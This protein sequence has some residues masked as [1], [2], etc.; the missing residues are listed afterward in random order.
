M[1]E[2]PAY[3]L[4]LNKIVPADLTEDFD[5]GNMLS[6]TGYSSDL[7]AQVVSNIGGD[8]GAGDYVVML[9]RNAK[10]L[11]SVSVASRQYD[12]SMLSMLEVLRGIGY[13]SPYRELLSATDI[14]CPTQ[15]VAL[16]VGRTYNSDLL[17]RNQTGSFGYGWSFEWDRKLTADDKGNLSVTLDSK[18]AM[19]YLQSD[20][21]FFSSDD[22]VTL[23]KNSSGY[24]MTSKDGTQLQYATDGSLRSRKDANGNTVTATYSSG[25][26]TKLAHSN[27]QYLTFAR[28]SSGY[29]SSVTD[30]QG[31]KV[32]YTY[33]SKGNLT[34]VSDQAAGTMER[35]TYASTSIHSLTSWTAADGTTTNFTYGADGLLSQI[36][37]RGGE[38]AVTIEYGPE[39]K[40]TVEDKQGGSLTYC[41][42]ECGRVVKTVDNSTGVATTYEHGNDGTIVSDSRG[43]S[44]EIGK[45]SSGR[46]TSLTD[47]DGNSLSLT[48][49]SKGNIA[50]MTDMYGNTAN[51]TYD[52]KNNVTRVSHSDG[53]S[54]SMT[55][56]SNG[57]L[58]TYK[59]TK[60]ITTSFTYNTKG[61]VLSSARNGNTTSY[62]YDSNGNLAG[63]T[64]A[65]SSASSFQYDSQSHLSVFTDAKGNSINYTYDAKGNMTAIGRADGTSETFTYNAYNDLTT[66]KNR[67][68]GTVKY[69]Y[70]A[71]G[72]VTKIVKSDGTTIQY[73]YDSQS[74]LTQAGGMT[75]TYDAYDNLKTQTL[76]GKTLTYQYDSQDRIVSISDGNSTTKYSYTVQG[77]L[78]KLTNA[79]GALLVD[80]DYD[81]QGRLSKVTNGNGTYSRYTYNQYGELSAI[82]NY[83]ASGSLT[84]YNRYTYDSNG[85]C[86]TKTTKDGTWTYTY[87]KIGQLTAAVL[88]NSS[89]S[90][91]RNESY[92]YDTVGN[93]VKSVIDGVTTTYVYDA[94]NRIVSATVGGKK[95]TYRYD[96]DGNLLEDEKRIYTWTTDNRV[97]TEKDKA[98]GQIWTYGYDALGNRISSTTNGVTTTWAV[99]ANGN[100]LAE[101]VNGVWQRSYIQ[102]SGLAGWTDKNGNTY[103]FSSD[104]LCSTIAVTDKNG[105]TVNTYSY[106]SFGN[107]ISANETVDNAFQFVG[108]YGLM[109]NESGTI[110][111]RA[112]NYDPVTGRWISEDPIGIN[113]GENLYVYCENNPISLIDLYGYS[114]LSI[115]GRTIENGSILDSKSGQRLT[116]YGAETFYPADGGEGP[117]EKIKNNYSP[118]EGDEFLK[119]NTNTG[120]GSNSQQNGRNP[121]KKPSSTIYTKQGEKITVEL[122]ENQISKKSTKQA[123]QQLLRITAKAIEKKGIAWTAKFLLK[124]GVKLTAK[125]GNALFSLAFLASDFADAKEIAD[126][127]EQILEEENDD[128]SVSNINVDEPKS[129]TVKAT[130][131][132]SLTQP[133]DIYRTFFISQVG[134]TATAGQDF[135]NFSGQQVVIAPRQTSATFSVT[136]NSDSEEE[137]EEYFEVRVSTAENDYISKVRCTIWDNSKHD[138]VVAVID[139]SGSMS[140]SRI[141][142][143]KQA[144]VRVVNSM[145]D[146]DY[147]GVVSFAD[148]ASTVY[149]LNEMSDQT[150]PAAISAINGVSAGGGTYIGAGLDA[151]AYQLSMLI[152]DAETK[153]I[154]LMSDGEDGNPSGTR[155]VANRIRSYGYDIYGIGYGNAY[156]RSIS[157]LQ[158]IVE[159][160]GGKYYFAENDKDLEQMFFD[161]AAAT[162]GRKFVFNSEDSV[163]V[164][165]ADVFTV[166]VDSTTTML[167]LGANWKTVNALE[168]VAIDPDGNYFTTS[169]NSP[170]MKYSSTSDT[171]YYEISAPTIGTWAFG[172]IGADGLTGT[173]NYTAY[174]L[175]T[176]PLSADMSFSATVNGV[177]QKVGVSL[178]VKNGDTAVIGATA[179]A[180]ILR[181][182]GTTETLDLYDDG[183]HGDG[184][185][186]DGVYANFTKQTAGGVYKVAGVVEGKLSSGDTFRRQTVQE[187]FK[188]DPSLKFGI[189]E[190]YSSGSLVDSDTDMS[191]VILKSGGNNSMFVSEGGVATSTI[192]SSGGSVVVRNGGRTEKTVLQ[193]GGLEMISSGGTADGTIIQGIRYSGTTQYIAKGGL[194]INT[195]IVG[196]TSSMYGGGQQLIVGGNAIGTVIA[197]GGIQSLSSGAIASNTVISKYGYQTVWYCSAFDTTIEGG[198]QHVRGSAV[199]TV[200]NSGVQDV[201][202][203]A[204]STIINSGGTQDVNCYG[205]FLPGTNESG[206]SGGTVSHTVINSGGKQVVN[207]TA[208][209][210]ETTVNAGGVQSVYGKMYRS[211]PDDYLSNGHGIISQ[212]MVNSGG[213]VIV[214]SEGVAK[215]MVVSVGGNL[216]LYSGAILQDR[217][218]WGGNISVMSSG[219]IVADEAEIVFDITQ[220]KI[221]DT[222]I[223][224]NIAKL[225]G[226]TYFVSVSA[227]QAEGQYKLANNA[228]AFNQSVTLT[229]T[230]TQLTAQLTKGVTKTVNGVGYTLNVSNGTLNLN[231]V[232]NVSSG[233]TYNSRII[234]AGSLVLSNG[235]TAVST[236]VLQSGQVIV[237]SGGTAKLTRVSSGG[238]VH[239]SSGGT[240]LSTTLISGGMRVSSGGT[241]TGIN[242]SSGVFLGLTIARDTYIQGTSGGKSFTMTSV[243]SSIEITSGYVDVLR[244]GTLVSAT[245]NSGGNLYAGVGGTISS[246][247]VKSGGYLSVSSGGMVSSA[248]V[249]SGGSLYVIGGGI[250]HGSIELGGMM[251]FGGA[252]VASGANI[253]FDVSQRKI[254]DTVIVNDVTMVA[255][256]TYSVSVAGNQTNGQYKLA[257]N[258]SSFSQSVILTVKD[259]NLATTLTKGVK[260]TVGGKDYTLSVVSG[261]LCLTVADNGGIAV[262]TNLSGNS[263]KLSWSAVSGTSGYVVEYSRDNFAT[264]IS[265]ETATTALEHYNVSSSTWQWRVRAK[266]GAAWAVGNNIVVSSASMTPSVVSAT[267][268]GVKDAFFVKPYGTWDS[269]YRAQ[270]MGVSGGWEGT[271]EKVVFGGENRFGDIFFGST[272]ENVMLLTDDSNGDALFI[273][274]IY[275]ASKNNL[276]KTQARL[277]NIKE[278]RAGAGNDIVDLTSDKF[279][280]TGSGL[281]IHGGL[282]NDTLWAN[283]GNNYLFGDAG[284]DRLVGAT[285]TDVIVG[286][287]GNDSMHGG[288][289]TDVFA[290]GDYDWGQDTIEQVDGGNVRLWFAEGLK[291][292]NSAGDIKLTMDSDGNAVV[293]RVG[294]E[295]K[296]TVK[297]YSQSDISN[298]LLWGNMTFNSLKYNDLNTMGAFAPYTTEHVFEEKTRG[299]LA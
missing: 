122:A 150:R 292:G 258:A 228:S 248:I 18:K 40:T 192:V 83:S 250:L 31:N 74:R 119:S 59:D 212:T 5:I 257:G 109:Q 8:D 239:V 106:D 70:D 6:V 240:A 137:G 201:D 81:S 244:D 64:Y 94:M 230:N 27:G 135:Q 171:G 165:K 116:T 211:S 133:S 272:D 132:I 207:Y 48:Y 178:T 159:E 22:S 9:N 52:S 197:S 33:D 43:N 136:I 58:A 111:V 146:G 123:T 157:V 42:D 180:D 262:P 75:F 266:E 1:P 252:A 10:Y 104:L 124:Q 232:N 259:T 110:F 217:Q 245:V 90:V 205:W 190:L 11:D 14:S 36:S 249:N 170:L 224:N 213:C 138:A 57:T 16:S 21:S 246:T 285:G 15:G 78:D 221:S 236:T 26:L 158:E 127:L 129:G 28:N 222:V 50:S 29:V 186:N 156:T 134:G 256:G 299:Q 293:Q 189:V 200:V 152:E 82:D 290:F 147:V 263:S 265:V 91:I 269:T 102:G 254:S 67:R 172:V 276:G 63:I 23:T 125:V 53:T 68:G 55:Y 130:F 49:D 283:T 209:A 195:V 225:D 198:S 54:E 80:Y 39:G 24:L 287:F 251:R 84:S 140:G 47:G 85:R 202:G 2:A 72:D 37:A 242:A 181:P 86:A 227:S 131:T 164:G 115:T 206:L 35:Y 268:D 112:R 100:V 4:K 77:D 191:G 105:R 297:G 20:G 218:V 103:Y 145:A 183:K 271:G 176:S 149:T 275:T 185:A 62:S 117:V 247:T 97:L 92:Q 142:S 177:N 98:T 234:S 69:T 155:A 34:T 264:V 182:D 279:D 241:A 243:A 196:N 216:S 273:D 3:S 214:A 204:V 113:G 107:V 168:L 169:V 289:G 261:N 13:L 286:G 89:G 277:A 194:A 61:Q 220:R 219:A 160:L 260:A 108:G 231:V 66:W 7:V 121:S 203:Y 79:S 118:Q 179:H 46:I 44:I 51:Y 154:I 237:A 280:Y 71:S 76:N 199:R 19:F 120:T 282:G 143:A 295:N 161:L 151:A 167:R 148:S 229:V 93:R 187:Q 17:S 270:H 166:T 41:Y 101:Y 163:T 294:T 291:L 73:A 193:N 226:G 288:G 128:F 281:A 296:V 95:T 87:D 88:K 278:I 235:D 96:A 45:D 274:D 184:A 25:K 210:I 38:N 255:G 175:A 126:L 60:G 174:A 253:V 32:T 139:R 233:S 238:F 284:D 56:N 141:A 65:D 298:R 215:D 153:S 12:T 173:E 267:S 144:A 223:L 208:T 162:G 30:S 114:E 188:I 99:D